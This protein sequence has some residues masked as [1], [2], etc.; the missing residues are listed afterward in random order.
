MNKCE[1]I[2]RHFTGFSYGIANMNRFFVEG[3]DGEIYNYGS[4][5]EML[6]A[7]DIVEE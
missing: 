2:V 5:K 3:A 7:W 1:K 4:K 6:N